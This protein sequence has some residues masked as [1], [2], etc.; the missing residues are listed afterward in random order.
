M[1][2]RERRV[3]FPGHGGIALAGLWEGPRPAPRGVL[4][5]AHCFTC[6]KEYKIL[7]R[8]A[9]ALA[10]LGYATLRFD[11]AG[12]GESEGDFAATTLETNVEDLLAASRFAAGQGERLAAL[13]GH[14]LGGAAAL[15]AAQRL[16]GGLP[17]VVIGTS[18]ASGRRI[19]ERLSPAQQRELQETGRTEIRIGP[20]SYPL[21]RDFLEDLRNLSLEEVVGRGISPILVV[22]GTSDRIVPIHEGERLF[23]AAAEPKAFVAVPGGDHLLAERKEW[24]TSLAAIMDGWFQM[25]PGGR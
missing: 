6:R 4:V 13:L 14:S 16:G 15:L 24:A 19:A 3:R 9:D 7:A 5:M 11:F 1:S 12:L 10:P 22:H 23:A 20:A 18:S 25:L 2:S 17:V 21:A 8:L